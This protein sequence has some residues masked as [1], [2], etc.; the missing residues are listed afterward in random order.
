M[1]N[2]DV[3]HATLLYGRWEVIPTPFFLP[4]DQIISGGYS[5]KVLFFALFT[6]TLF[7][8]VS[9]CNAFTLPFC[10]LSANISTYRMLMTK[11]N[12]AVSVTIV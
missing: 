3:L 2:I 5:S 4:S 1:Y 9:C 11:L 7:F 12:G 8:I 10:R 6:I